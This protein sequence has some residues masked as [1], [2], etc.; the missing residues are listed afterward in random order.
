[1]ER[2][3]VIGCC[4]AGKTT[5]SRQIQKK[6]GFPLFHLDQYYWKSGWQEPDPSTWQN[7]VKKLASREKWIIDG[8]YGGT[9][10]IRIS[11]ADTIVYLNFSTFTCLYRVIKRIFQ[12]YGKVRSEMPPGCAERFDWKFLHYVS[13]FRFKKGKDLLIKLKKL[14]N[15]KNV[16]ILRNDRDVNRFL[17]KSPSFN[18]SI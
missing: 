16:I 17:S 10:D 7:V 12:H 2:I 1:M 9:I 14:S 5:I 6:L 18:K 3:I 8:N 13:T 4:G 11:R 15:T